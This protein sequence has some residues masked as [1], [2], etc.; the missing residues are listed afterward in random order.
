MQVDLIVDQ[1]IKKLY[2]RVKVRYN[3][4][5]GGLVGW[6]VV[7]VWVVEERNRAWR[8]NGWGGGLLSP[9]KEERNG[10]V[11]VD[12]SRSGGISLGE[13]NLVAMYDSI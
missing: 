10:K 13:E 3:K 4:W 9:E 11:K 1:K 2:R 7:Y 6:L 5:Y 8:G 12:S